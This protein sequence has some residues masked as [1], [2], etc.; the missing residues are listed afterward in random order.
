MDIPNGQNALACW[1]WFK[2][3]SDLPDV[4]IAALLG[5]F[6]AES[7]FMPNNLENRANYQF[8]ISDEGYCKAVNDKSYSRERFVN[9]AAGFGLAQWTYGPRKA[10]LYDS[11]VAKNIPVENLNTQCEYALYELKQLFPSVY[12]FIKESND[13]RA[14][15]VKV[16]CEYENPA[17]QSDRMKSMRTQ[18][19]ENIYQAFHS[20]ESE[21]E[22]D[23]II[24][25]IKTKLDKLREV[26]N[27]A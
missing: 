11:T 23:Q 26:L 5:N 7:G 10:K 15:T 27:G 3:N 14:S 2:N 25:D 24:N 13:I 12:K 17:D 9:D 21:N 4:A 6:Q 16:L 22:A 8:N 20:K 18:Y 1:N 19:A